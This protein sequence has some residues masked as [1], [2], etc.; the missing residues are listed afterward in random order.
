MSIIRRSAQTCFRLAVGRDPLCL[1][2][3]DAMLGATLAAQPDGN[4]SSGFEGQTGAQ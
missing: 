2:Y 4:D 1:R 3:L